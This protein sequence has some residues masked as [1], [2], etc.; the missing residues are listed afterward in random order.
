MTE[1][2]RAD[3]PVLLVLGTLFVLA[4]LGGLIFAFV[5]REGFGVAFAALFVGGIGLG[6]VNAWRVPALVIAPGH[7]KIATFFGQRTI[8]APKGHP[9]G[10][11]IG[12]LNT[13]TRQRG[14]LEERKFARFMTQDARG[15]TVELIAYQ[16]HT[17]DVQK[18]H[19][20]LHAAG[21]AV[22]TL[23]QDPS[24]RQSRPDLSHW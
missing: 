16:Q 14:S 18:V 2:R 15:K 6:M 8:P 11:F 19:A 4:G 24:T 7:F 12:Y 9:V 3:G 21:Y 22:E 17:P 13:G 20:A 10:V 1:F 23:E 5:M